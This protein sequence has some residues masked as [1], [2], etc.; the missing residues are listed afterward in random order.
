ML[1]LVVAKETSLPLSTVRL[2]L[3]IRADS[4]DWGD[5][6]ATL[7]SDAQGRAAFEVEPGK[8]MELEIQQLLEPLSSDQRQ[9]PALAP[10][11]QREVRIELANA[12]DLHYWARVVRDEDGARLP[13]VHA[14]LVYRNPIGDAPI[15]QSLVADG[16]ALI[17]IHTATWKDSVLLVELDGFAQASARVVPGHETSE[18]A[19]ELRLAGA[20]RLKLLVTNPAGAPLPS[21]TVRATAAAYELSQSDFWFDDAEHVRSTFNAVS[22]ANGRATLSD[23]PSRVDI[24]LSVLEGEAVLM[25]ERVKQRLDPGQEREVTLVVGGKATLFGRAI[26]QDGIAVAGEELWLVKPD[27]SMGMTFRTWTNASARRQTDTEGGFEFKDI[28]EGEWWVGPGIDAAMSSI[29]SSPFAPYGQ[30]VVIPPGAGRAEV[31]LH[32]WRGI[33]IRGHV[34]LASGE[35][36]VGCNVLTQATDMDHT[37]FLSTKSIEEGAF[38]LGPLCGVEYELR[39]GGAFQGEFAESP[40]VLAKGGAE[41]V[42]LVVERSA[43]L[44]GTVIDSQSSEPCEAMIFITQANVS[45]GFAR[46]MGS[47]TRENSFEV[48]GISAGVWDISVTARNARMGTTRVTLVPGETKEIVLRVSPS[49]VLSF[50]NTSDKDFFYLH[51]SSD[52]FAMELAGVDPGQEHRFNLPPGRISL[53]ISNAKAKTLTV[54]EIEIAPGASGEIRYPD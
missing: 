37:G 21:L 15:R 20:A 48:T 4:G 50:K 18:R 12:L 7:E 33:Y 51:P 26:D 40:R 11:E 38:E 5:P 1:V 23:L 39:A 54:R 29:P 36:A 52:G 44:R 30:R 43:I 47:Q 22:D 25:R 6:F 3:A 34:R 16:E 10:G 32:V 53:R 9:I 31:V 42:V 27:T 28:A 14:T 24:E 19:F 41:D 2:E 17:E 46:A 45:D 13:F 8:A 35:P 49:V